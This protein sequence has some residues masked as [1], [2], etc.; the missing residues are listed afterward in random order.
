MLAISGEDTGEAH[1][2]NI[3]VHMISGKVIE[4]YASSEESFARVKFWI[5]VKEGFLPY[6]QR[7]FRNLVEVDGADWVEES[8]DIS[9]VVEN[10]VSAMY[11]ILQCCRSVEEIFRTGIAQHFEGI[12]RVQFLINVST[13]DWREN[14]GTFTEDELEELYV[15]FE[16]HWVPYMHFE[17]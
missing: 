2:V 6:Q 7:L 1:I 15:L 17:R 4:V 5:M 9:L 3:C 11:K 14:V 10:K 8:C 13:R 16:T 12:H